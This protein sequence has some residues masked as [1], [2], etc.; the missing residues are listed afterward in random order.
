M[1]EIGPYK[2]ISFYND[3]GCFTI[4]IEIQR[5]MVFWYFSRFSTGREELCE[6]EIN[7]SS[8]EPQIRDKNERVWIF[9]NPFYY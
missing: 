9:K 5:G 4:Y 3:S 7:V 8:I 1:E 2:H 6:K